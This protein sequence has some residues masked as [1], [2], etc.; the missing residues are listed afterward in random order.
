[1][2][3]RDISLQADGTTLSEVPHTEEEEGG[4]QVGVWG[5]GGEAEKN[6]KNDKNEKIEKNESEGPGPLRNESKGEGAAG[7]GRG[8]VGE[9]G[10]QELAPLVCG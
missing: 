5:T 8:G 3:E 1:M 6:E 2:K 7:G 9:C 4:V 10:D